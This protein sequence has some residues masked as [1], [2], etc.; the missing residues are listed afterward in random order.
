MA[1]Q[2]VS[3]A[4][5][6]VTGELAKI[7][8]SG[9]AG[10]L[11]DKQA[12]AAAADKKLRRLELLLIKVHSA[13]EASEKHAIE[14]AW[15]VKWRDKFKEAAAEGDE[16]LTG[17]G[18]PAAG[19]AQQQEHSSCAASAPATTTGASSS[20]RNAPS[21]MVY[22]IRGASSED[23]ERLNSAVEKLE[24]LSP[25]IGDFIKLLKV[26]ILALESKSA[27]TKRKGSELTASTNLG[28]RR[29]KSTSIGNSDR[30][31]LQ[32]GMKASVSMPTET[33]EER[34]T[35]SDRYHLLGMMFE[36]AYATICWAVNLT[37]GRDLRGHEWLA[38][39]GSIVREAKGQG[40]AV[41]DAFRERRS[42]SGGAGAACEQAA[43]CNGEEDSDFSELGRFVCGM[44]SLAEEV[45]YF[46]DLAS[47]CPSY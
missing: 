27:A 34:N 31:V 30:I 23:I 6:A 43:E 1:E 9:F 12:A 46:V 32:S 22:C 5:S 40:R 42:R 37:A 10:R 8:F 28:M 25:E 47:L 17:F 26:E 2:I 45:H 7:L 13:V 35:L 41:L 33:E 15:L 16:V 21:S 19:A 3:S 20:A 24:E 4:A 11:V 14:N 38:H 39:W 18:Q 29:A 36:Q 44:E